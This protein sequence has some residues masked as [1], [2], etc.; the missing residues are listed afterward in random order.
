MAASGHHDEVRPI[1]D[2]NKIMKKLTDTLFSGG[3]SLLHYLH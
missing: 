3:Y 2:P 1:M